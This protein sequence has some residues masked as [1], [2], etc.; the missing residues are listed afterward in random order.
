VSICIAN[1]A[2]SAQKYTKRHYPLTRVFF[3]KKYKI[4]D[5]LIIKRI[6]IIWKIQNG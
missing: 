3:I 6:G 1:F 5:L 4:E 2:K